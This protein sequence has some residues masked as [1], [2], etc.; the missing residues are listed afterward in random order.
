M[1][2]GPLPRPDIDSRFFWKSGGEGVLRFLQCKACDTFVHPPRPVCPHCLSEQVAPTP[3]AG[4][5]IIDSFTINRQKWHP[6]LPVPFV[7]AR[8][9]IDGA[10]GVI[11][12][13]NV[14]DCDPEAIEIGDRVQVHFEQ[15]ED[16]W[17]PL[18]RL[19]EGDGR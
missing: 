11:L 14:T 1:P 5:G 17:L 8:I 6:S 19:V 16:V 9:A 10:P 13:S 4:S 7:I 3:V 12:T 18:F 2:L 15:A